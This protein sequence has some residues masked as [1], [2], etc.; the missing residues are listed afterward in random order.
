MAFFSHAL[1]PT[2]ALA[3]RSGTTPERNGFFARLLMAM[4]Q[5][6]QHQA[7]REI[8]QYLARCGGKLTDASER[9]IERRFLAGSPK[10]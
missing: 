5:S 9:E 8:A 10:L 7:D 2:D 4:M 6:R 3:A 1:S